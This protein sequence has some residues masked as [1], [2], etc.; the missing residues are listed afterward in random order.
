MSKS[1]LVRASLT[2]I[3]QVK[4]STF[5]DCPDLFEVSFV[6][7][8]KNGPFSPK[9]VRCRGYN[10]ACIEFDRLADAA[11]KCAVTRSAY[12]VLKL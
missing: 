7:S 5:P 6:P 12:V 1:K 2:G 9:P 10:A 8:I 4:L 3:G 11:E